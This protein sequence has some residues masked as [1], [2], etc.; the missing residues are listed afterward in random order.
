MTAGRKGTQ[1]TE[2]GK[3]EPYMPRP[4]GDTK[5]KEADNDD[6]DNRRSGGTFG[7]PAMGR[8]QTSQPPASVGYDGRK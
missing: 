1:A 3:T 7:T 8:D 5:R 4:W 6:V 2:G